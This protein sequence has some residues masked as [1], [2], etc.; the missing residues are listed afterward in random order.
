V[1]ENISHPKRVHQPNSKEDIKEHFFWLG[2]GFHDTTPLLFLISFSTFLSVF[3][4]LL[5]MKYKENYFRYDEDLESGRRAFENISTFISD[6]LT[7]RGCINMSSLMQRKIS[8]L[9]NLPICRK[10][11][12]K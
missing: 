10:A 2:K 8:S 7:K 5:K 11:K 3:T 4:H 9:L 1:E 6:C 12:G